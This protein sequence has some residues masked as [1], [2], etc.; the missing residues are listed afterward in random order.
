MDIDYELYKIFYRV[1]VAGSFTKG[2]EELHITQ[3]A[4]SQ[5]IKNLESRLGTPLFLRDGRRI[6][7]SQ[8]G[9]VLFRHIAQ[10]ILNFSAG[11]RSLKEMAGF[12]SGEVRIGVGDTI[13]RYHLVPIFKSFAEAYPGIRIQVKN[14]TSSGILSLLRSGSIDFGIVSLPAGPGQYK[15][16]LF[17]T[18]RDVFVASGRYEVLQNRSC[19]ID[20][21]VN[22]PLLLLNGESTTRKLLDH[23][24]QSR[25][26]KVVPAIELE[27][28]DLLEEFAKIG[29][30]IAHV[31][32]LSVQRAISTGELF[33]INTE[34]AL[35]ERELGIVSLGA[36]LPS[37]AAN[38]MC[39][40]ILTREPVPSVY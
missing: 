39:E 4:V 23:F 29:F 15:I 38:L 11:E 28:M 10:G 20:E 5:A 34:P 30:G 37:R 2:A 27:S 14:R 36:T 8:E 24:L 19:D 13:C 7:R 35:P 21:L 16:Q 25:G 17:R 31:E 9:E 1:A 18:V 26:I 6:R 3:S 40:F 32:E 12:D 33:I 22:Y